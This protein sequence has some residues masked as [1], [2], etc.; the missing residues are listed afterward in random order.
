MLVIIAV[1]Y[2]FREEGN[3][4]NFGYLPQVCAFF[5]AAFIITLVVVFT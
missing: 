3:I 2:C 4:T 5:F 1:D